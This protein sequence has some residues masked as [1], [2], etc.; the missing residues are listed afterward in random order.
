MD[1]DTHTDSDGEGP[2]S[3]RRCYARSSTPVRE[4]GP[5]LQPPELPPLSEV[6]EEEGEENGLDIVEEP[7]AADPVAAE[8]D[9]D[10]KQEDTVCLDDDDDIND[11]GPDYFGLSDEA[12]GKN[13]HYLHP[14]DSM[15]DVCDI[16]MHPP[17]L[18]LTKMPYI[19]RLNFQFVNFSYVVLYSQILVDSMTIIYDL[20]CLIA[21]LWCTFQL[22]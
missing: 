7:I 11:E 9:R 5:P 19:G 13:Y 16:H 1:S 2:P 8:S 12:M 22:L 15:A 21:V 18:G 17:L 6:K 14:C 20:T 4:L 3:K 10:P